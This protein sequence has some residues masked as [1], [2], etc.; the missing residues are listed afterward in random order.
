MEKIPVC[1]GEIFDKYSIL[2]IKNEKIEDEE[3]LK[4][5]RK[6]MSHLEPI[7]SKYKLDKNIYLSLKKINLTIWDCEDIIR[8]KHFK[9]EF[10]NEFIDLAKTIYTVN[11]ERAVLK[12]KINKIFNSEIVEVK[13]YIKYNNIDI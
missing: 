10:D 5:V 9:N 4:H 12:R 8:K 11:D 7:L 6:E 13:K 3:K 1:I 2:D